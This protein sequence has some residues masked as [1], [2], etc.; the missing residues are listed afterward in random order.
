MKLLLTGSSGFIGRSLVPRL[1]EAG[2]QL[3]L[4]AHRAQ[5]PSG[6][7]VVHSLDALGAS[8]HFDG[9]INLSGAPIFDHRW[10]EARKQVIWESRVDLTHRLMTVLERLDTPPSVLISGSAIGIYGDQGDRR[11]S[12]DSPLIQGGFGQRLC[13]AWE[14]A[15]GGHSTRS[16]RTIIV[17]TGLVVGAGGGFLTPMIRSF[18]L[19]LGGALGQGTQ[20]MSWIHLEDVLRLIMTLLERSDA[21][22]IFNL[23][24]PEPVTNL[25]FTQSLAKALGR[26]AKLPMPASLLHLMMGERAGL[27]LESQR[28]IPERAA[29]LGYSF[30][31]ETLAPALNQVL[32]SEGRLA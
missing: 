15:A 14:A 21:S 6:H 32:T 28:V 25:E 18:R 23:T 5:V 2:H 26:R 24:A 11:L 29:A 22:G 1:A 31:Y 20:Y 17:R 10:S 16:L 19:G 13:A 7:E 3:T 27:L 30:R 4:L 8:R 9:V 12:E